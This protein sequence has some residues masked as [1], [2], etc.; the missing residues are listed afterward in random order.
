MVLSTWVLKE[1]LAEE[2]PGELDLSTWVLKEEL[3]EELPGEL[4]LGQP[5]VQPQRGGG[6]IGHQ[7][8]E[9]II[10]II[11]III[12]RYGTGLNKNNQ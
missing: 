1:E 8:L 2:L 4:D 11:I 12:I 10:I 7:G 9:N 3:G 5:L 6:R